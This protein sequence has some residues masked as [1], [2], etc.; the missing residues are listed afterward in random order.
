MAIYVAM[1]RGINVGPHN[2]IKMPALADLFSELGHT[3][4]VTYIQSGNVVFKS[5]SKSAATLARNIEKRIASDLGCEV[6]VLLRSQEELGRAVKANPFLKQKKADP[7]H[8]HVTFLAGEP[9]AA[10]VRAAKEFDVGHDEF[11]VR[12]RDVYLHCPTG[13]GNT[14][15]N[16]G[17]FEKKLKTLATTRNWNSVTKLLELA[18]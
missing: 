4:V 2:R 11:V 6:A 17:Y 16:N 13:Y 7:K 1:L 3:D 9:D 18:G 5:R 12:G 14:K 15:I 10:L 8:L